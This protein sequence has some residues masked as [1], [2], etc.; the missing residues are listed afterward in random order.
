MEQFF[1]RSTANA[2][3]ELP[4][5]RPDGT[6]TEHIIRIR[7]VHSDAFKLANAESHRRIVAIAAI[8]DKVE[9]A[10]AYAEEETRLVA[11]L[12]SEWTFDMPCT[13]E[14]VFNFLREAPQIAQEVNRLAAQ[15]KAFTKAVSAS[16]SNSPTASSS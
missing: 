3:V 13:P 10:K 11:S 1:T 6:P 14:N 15:H 16:S 4:L 5:S 7:G 8:E 12:V 9:R 2:G